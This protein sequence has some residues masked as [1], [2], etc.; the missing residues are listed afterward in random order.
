MRSIW[1]SK[2]FK[3]EIIV[4]ILG[5]CLF[6]W[7]L[8]PSM[9]FLWNFTKDNAS[10]WA[11]NL[12]ERAIQSAAMGQRNW[13][14]TIMFSMIWLIGI[15]TMGILIAF[16]I[17]MIR[18]SKK[19]PELAE[20]MDGELLQKVYPFIASKW[21]LTVLA[22]LFFYESY[23]GLRGVFIAGVDLQLVTSF[24][25]RLTAIAPY[26][27]P[28]EEKKLRSLWAL[29]RNRKDF[30]QIN[31]QIEGHA[32]EAGIKLPQPMLQ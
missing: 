7:L 27:E 30:E 6:T 19:D 3:S 24:N 26:I 25:Q 13:V 23:V 8:D 22:L 10:S 31:K 17:I 4:G 2:K 5:A 32:K 28:I 15:M 21:F 14:D 1:E 9:R 16:F 18:R 11:E 20:K 12:Q 29:M